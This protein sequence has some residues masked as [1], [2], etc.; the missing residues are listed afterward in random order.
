MIVSCTISRPTLGFLS[1]QRVGRSLLDL[2]LLAALRRRSVAQLLPVL[3]TKPPNLFNQQPRTSQLPME[4]VPKS[5]RLRLRLPV[6]QK[7]KSLKMFKWTWSLPL[8]LSWRVHSYWSRL[9]LNLSISSIRLSVK[10]REAMVQVQFSELIWVQPNKT[11]K[12]K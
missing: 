8:Q 9:T 12:D 11:Y 7:T 2:L 4:L 6:H 3:E 1:S 5:Q 10:L